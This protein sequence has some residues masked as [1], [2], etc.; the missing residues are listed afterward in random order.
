[1]KTTTHL[2]ARAALN[3]PVGLEVPF[4]GL[5]LVSRG[6]PRDHRLRILRRNCW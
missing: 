3:T 1:M 4:L 5:W 6:P 2:K